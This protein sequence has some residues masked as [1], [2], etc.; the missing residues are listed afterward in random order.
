[1]NISAFQK[2]PWLCGGEWTGE[3]WVDTDKL[4]KEGTAATQ[5]SEDDRLK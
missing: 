2:A 5:P 1:M 4:I 3:G